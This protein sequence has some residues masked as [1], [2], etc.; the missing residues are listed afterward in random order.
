MNGFRNRDICAMLWK[1][2]SSA[3]E[4]RRRA[5]Q[6][7]RRLGLLRAHGLVRKISGTYRYILTNKGQTTVTALL[8]ARRADVTQ[9]TQLAA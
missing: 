2:L 9:L 4:Q 1:Y 5:G 6:V 7:T 8:A 3:K